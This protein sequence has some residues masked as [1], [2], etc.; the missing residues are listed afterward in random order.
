MVA[1]ELNIPY[2]VDDI[3]FPDLKKPEFLAV[4]P[5]GRMPALHDPNTNL[6][7]WESGAIIEYLVDKYDTQQKISF[8][9][10]SNDSYLARQ[11]LFFQGEFP[12]GVG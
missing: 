12:R 6:T 10:G 11:W 7:I 9:P 4:N 3:G 1:E 5:N 8:A 2:Q